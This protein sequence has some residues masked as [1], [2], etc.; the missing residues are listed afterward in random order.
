MDQD[1]RSIEQQQ[2]AGAPAS[3]KSGD[4]KSWSRR[5]FG[6]GAVSA[7]V[8]MS[9]HAQP[10]KA[11][12]NCTPSGWVSGNTSLHQE[13][14]EC[15]GRTPGYWQNDNHPHHPQGWRETY[16]E[17]LNS[18]HGFPGLNGLTGSGTNGEAT[19]LDAVSGPGRQD[20]GMGDSTLRQVVRF[21][22]AAL[23]NARYPSVSPGYPLS[24]SEVVDIVTQTLMAGEYVTS[25]GDVLDEEQVHR[26][27][28][29]TM[30]SPSWGP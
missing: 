6:V 28:A 4:P 1:K 11:A 2:G 30:D 14:E 21:G 24:E 25:S 22:T 3:A 27:L 26:F 16:Y 13:L 20:L 5:R 23:L 12:A 29:N 19:L 15:G 18:N 9:L 10:L 8:I 17:A 7:S